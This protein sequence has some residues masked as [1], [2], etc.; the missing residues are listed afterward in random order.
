MINQHYSI[1][2][3]NHGSIVASY[4]N[5]NIG[6]K[7]D[8]IDIDLAH[9]LTDDL[10]KG[11]SKLG[12]FVTLGYKVCNTSVD[13]NS[14]NYNDFIYC[15]NITLPNKE[16]N[17]ANSLASWSED[18]HLNE[19]S[20]S[21]NIGFLNTNQLNNKGTID[22]ANVTRKTIRFWFDK[23]PIFGNKLLIALVSS[24]SGSSDFKSSTL[25]F[26]TAT[27]N[28]LYY[29]EYGTAENPQIF[30]VSNNF[31][32]PIKEMKVINAL[33]DDEN[34]EYSTSRKP[35]KVQCLA[36]QSRTA[37]LTGWELY[38]N[39]YGLNVNRNETEVATGY[40]DGGE[41]CSRNSDNIS[42]FYLNKG[43]K[44]TDENY[45]TATN[46]KV[47]TNRWLLVDPKVQLDT[48]NGNI[49]NTS[50]GNIIIDN[51]LIYDIPVGRL[52][53]VYFDCPKYTHDETNNPYVRWVF[54]RSRI[55]FVIPP[56]IDEKG[57][58]IGKSY[59]LRYRIY[60]DLPNTN[61]VEGVKAY[62]NAY[63]SY[64]ISKED[65]NRYVCITICPR[66]EGILDNSAFRI[67]FDRC[68]TANKVYSEVA[69]YYFHTYQRP[70]VNIAYP[71]I[72]RNNAT[73]D[74]SFKYPQIVT[75]NILGN[76]QGENAQCVKY[77][78][79]SL[80][81]LTASPKEDAS[82]IPLFTRFYLAEYKFGR[83]DSKP[84]YSDFDELTSDHFD[85][86]NT[87]TELFKSPLVSRYTKREDI[88]QNK[89][90]D[91]Y[92]NNV[93]PI[94]QLTSIVRADNAPILF[95]GKCN[96]D[97]I[98]KLGQE[99][100]LWTFNSWKSINEKLSPQVP[101]MLNYEDQGS[102]KFEPDHY[103]Q[104][105]RND[106][107]ESTKD[108]S[109]LFRAGYVYLFK[110][111]MFHGAAAG[112]IPKYA[113]ET[114]NGY[115]I[116]GY[117]GEYDYSMTDKDPDNKTYYGADVSNNAPGY[118]KYD[119]SQYGAINNPYP[120]NGTN[121]TWV[122]PD[123]GTSGISLDDSRIEQTFPGFS[124]SDYTLFEPVV[125]YTSKKN[126]I[127]V[128]PTS[129]EIGANQAISF[130]YRHLSKNAGQI[131]NYAWNT[132]SNSYELGKFGV[133]KSGVQN[134]MTR[135]AAM[136]RYCVE[137]ILSKYKTFRTHNDKFNN[138]MSTSWYDDNLK[139]AINGPAWDSH[140]CCK[141]DSI[142]ILSEKIS[143][144][145][146]PEIPASITSYS[147]T[148][149]ESLPYNDQTST[150]YGQYVLIKNYDLLTE[151]D[152]Q[153]GYDDIINK[154]TYTNIIADN[155]TDFEKNINTFTG[156]L[157]Y[158]YNLYLKG[159]LGDEDHPYP[160]NFE[161]F[162]EYSTILNIR[163]ENSLSQYVDPPMGNS[164]RWQ[165][166]INAQNDKLEIKIQSCQE[167]NVFKDINTLSTEENTGD[168]SSVTP[169]SKYK[170]KDA[171][172]STEY[173][174]IDEYTG[175]SNYKSPNNV[176]MQTP[177]TQEPHAI[178]ESEVNRRFNIREFVGEWNYGNNAGGNYKNEVYHIANSHGWP[179]MYTLESDKE[180]LTSTNKNCNKYFAITN[181]CNTYG[182]LY[183]RVPHNQDCECGSSIVNETSENL[184]AIAPSGT[185][186]L[187][188]FN[189]NV[190][191]TVRTTHYLYFKTWI[192]TKFF[193]AVGFNLKIA[194]GHENDFHDPE[195]GEH[196]SIDCI[197]SD[198]ENKYVYFTGD[199]FISGGDGFNDGNYYVKRNI[200]NDAIIKYGNKYGH[201]E[202]YGEDNN[203]WGRCL[204]AEDET[205]RIINPSDGSINNCPTSGGIE[206]PIKVRYTPLLQPTILSEGSGGGGTI[207]QV[208]ST[209]KHVTVTWY[210]K[211]GS[212]SDI[213]ETLCAEVITNWDNMIP[214]VT[215]HYT[216][217][218]SMLIDSK[219]VES[220]NL[221]IG[222]PFIPEN[223]CYVTKHPNGGF[224]NAKYNYY[225][226]NIDYNPSIVDRNNLKDDDFFGGYGIC[227]NYTVLL[228]PSDPNLPSKTNTD[229]YKE[230]W[231][232]TAGHWN[233]YKQPAN[234]YSD[235]NDVLSIRSKSVPSAGPVIVA[236][237]Q[238]AAT[239]ADY[240]KSPSNKEK[241]R[242]KTTIEFNFNDL[243]KG[244]ST[245]SDKAL[246]SA[247]RLKTGVTYDL[248]IIPIYDSS[249]ADDLNTPYDY[250][251]ENGAGT[252]NEVPYGGGEAMK[253]D[254]IFAGSNP[255]VIYNYIQMANEV[256]SN[257]DGGGNTS[258]PDSYKTNIETVTKQLSN[259]PITVHDHA[260]VFPNVDS[261]HY[262]NNKE[263]PGFWL[264]NTFR[265]V[266][267]MPSYYLEKD[268]DPTRI[269]GNKHG[270][271]S[272]E[273]DIFTID[274]MSNGELKSGINTPNDFLFDD[275][276]IH[277]GKIDE[278]MSYSNNLQDMTTINAL[279]EEGRKKLHIFSYR[280]HP[281]IF[282]KKLQNSDDD[283][284]SLITGG[285]LTPS[286]ADE[287]NDDYAVYNNRFVTVNLSK[288]EMYDETTG[289]M[290]PIYTKHPEGYYI[291]FRCK[292]NYAGFA[293]SEWTAWHGG[294]CDGGTSWW[295]DKGI[296][297]FVPVR[298][299]SD[300]HT[301][302]RAP[303]KDSYEGS[304]ISLKTN[305]TAVDPVVG[306][307][308]I[309]TYGVETDGDSSRPSTPTIYDRSHG[310]YYYQGS[311]NTS[312][313]SMI[314]PSTESLT[315]TETNKEKS[316]QEYELINDDV[317]NEL[318]NY[319]TSHPELNQN[320]TPFDYHQ[321]FWDI[322]YV[323]YI[324]TNMCRLYYKIDNDSKE[325]NNSKALASPVD[326]DGN[327]IV[328]S[329]EAAGW[330]SVEQQLE[331]KY[332]NNQLKLS[333]GDEA[334]N[335][336][337]E[338]K[339][340]NWNR[341]KY[342]RKTINKQ[343]FDKLN[344]HCYNL[345]EFINNIS[346]FGTITNIAV[347]TIDDNTKNITSRYENHS[348]LLLGTIDHSELDYKRESRLIIGH[349]LNTNDHGNGFINT[350]VHLATD[351]NYIKR[352][353]EN[354]LS[355]IKTSNDK[356]ASTKRGIN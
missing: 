125:P 325:N 330:D 93:E 24:S 75:N 339:K 77:V 316:K 37:S 123:D 107:Y 256:I 13:F 244:K 351:S 116:Y 47:T 146:I 134:T 94:S 225:Y 136:Y 52:K 42:I 102:I 109:L 12:R 257:G 64:T 21:E 178:I 70:I 354:I 176:I 237:K 350:S 7:L 188:T 56:P 74:N 46:S 217:S 2:G 173:Y 349:N 111:R 352:T 320:P 63:C 301:Q 221:D 155:M 60:T 347:D 343:D 25:S 148:F 203:G 254:V 187:N 159:L 140:E 9:I 205:A 248:V 72:V 160:T 262:S 145:I 329:Y 260:I 306:Q 313:E 166:I 81:A 153:S 278:L 177:Y 315:R 235:L 271:A 45:T 277:I 135:I 73:G 302:F 36:I 323:D 229:I 98:S 154:F 48:G 307:G 114:K 59:I 317:G 144:G 288:C 249:T 258:T 83:A 348:I 65:A 26:P 78:A 82:G 49:V 337:K 259:C 279:D 233:F 20:I 226:Q 243:L 287:L 16:N 54:K 105:Y 263:T 220:Y 53:D 97:K 252:I 314:V 293:G 326:M 194:T 285:A 181:N 137:D 272:N 346:Y 15:T 22:I 106:K 184:S 157:S 242:A 142:D 141:H 186:S 269:S 115:I 39:S 298:N 295:G 121:D 282:S 312:D 300:I 120:A 119:K 297:Y 305:G 232:N 143:I 328:L 213:D 276:Q 18:I 170:D 4:R 183:E 162:P 171:K 30:T 132:T 332:S 84:G 126:L 66:D 240:L 175:S 99:N 239:M 55:C 182:R 227:T 28:G 68:Y 327:P 212:S 286:I 219:E 85:K 341:G 61:S 210:S 324:I 231:R 91:E 180:N 356:P 138:T 104:Q 291:Q 273:Y 311:G 191:P 133:T 224:D 174:Y 172:I 265:L 228:V 100:N 40:D 103:I 290:V 23:L 299:F 147:S 216:G 88:L 275:I 163:Q 284:R 281:E 234:Y 27:G 266:L 251:Y 193:C 62:R 69:A 179:S 283:A 267:R 71:K 67:E 294:S 255:A 223:G 206:V 280:D 34:I 1:F 247:N 130:N 44:T 270:N 303:M 230:C 261:L 344:E 31:S 289:T 214:K 76:F 127:T 117:G 198:F 131:D 209:R 196:K 35:A 50:N 340:Y 355:L 33:A 336:V 150:D 168:K 309:N 211:P 169:I 238:K 87:I 128:H 296:S 90:T 190:I 165:P 201:C 149:S 319:I 58:D 38:N 200:P 92:N 310:G 218:S 208:N 334:A 241:V 113:S 122:G 152:G 192:N 110:T 161:N 167:I 333:K 331:Q 5:F 139:A 43:D 96:D 195:T 14:L 151:I 158:F 95:S 292:T 8:Y 41:E 29:S 245:Y 101:N 338:H 51:R 185:V 86:I 222:Y 80:V 17:E 164:Y 345:Q 199:K 268:K 335:S 156:S 204:T 118:P 264:N 129:S 253:K 112:A 215:V 89:K 322:S 124:P 250:K 304:Y 197:K 274:S 6:D 3:G 57:N 342:Y 207:K 236:Y 108:M 189:K 318:Y 19:K 246:T 353:W 202:V 79:D 32:L 321:N 10:L 308:S 11:N